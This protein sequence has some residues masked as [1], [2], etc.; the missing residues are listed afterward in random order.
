MPVS[1][2]FGG[3]GEGWR[4]SPCGG[5]RGRGRRGMVDSGGNHPA[6]GRRDW[7]TASGS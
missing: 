5:G 7:R 3:V 2:G 6:G 4:G 1:S